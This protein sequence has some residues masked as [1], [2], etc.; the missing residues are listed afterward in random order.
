MTYNPV[1]T[2]VDQ[3]G[4]PT[5]SAATTLLVVPSAAYTSA[6]T[7]TAFSTSNI[8]YLAVDMNVTALTGG[9]SPAVNFF[10]Q[11]LGADGVWYL[12]SSLPAISTVS[13]VTF[14][15]GPGFA[16]TGLPNG[17]QHAVFTTQAR[18]GWTFTGAPTSVTFSA[19]VVGR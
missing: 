5:Q 13:T 10:L 6:N 1:M 18:F 8:T 19:S 4:L 12:V 2:L 17:T 11:R 9:T 14:D 7:G 15:V 3:N 16:S